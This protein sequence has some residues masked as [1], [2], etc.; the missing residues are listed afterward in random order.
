[1]YESLKNI[2]TEYKFEKRLDQLIDINKVLNSFKID[3]SN[4]VSGEIQLLEDW[5]RRRKFRNFT[6]IG[7]Y[8]AMLEFLFLRFF[9]KTLFFKPIYTFFGFKSNMYISK[10]EI[11]GRFIYFGFEILIFEEGYGY[12]NF[13]IRKISPSMSTPV[14]KGFLIRLERIGLNGKKFK[15]YKIR[16]MHAYS[17]FIHQFM[18]KNYGFNHQGK[19]KNDF[20]TTKWGKLLR[21]YWIDELPQLVNVLKGDMKIV[22]VRPVGEAYFNELPEEIKR[23]RLKIKPGCIPPYVSLNMKPNLDEVLQAELL[24]LKEY[25]SSKFVDV[26]YFF[27]A[28]YNIIFKRKRSS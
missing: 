4:V 5:K 2:K 23:V 17:E 10:A 16:T 22:G 20:R 25:N 9:P 21:K 8:V 18:I 13:K 11:L 3:D 7:L 24:Y 19:I 12:H 26:K 15:V 6:L 27:L 28:L 1:M 14:N